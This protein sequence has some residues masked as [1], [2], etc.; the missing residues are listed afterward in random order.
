MG[1]GG[2]RSE[3]DGD[4]EYLERQLD[5]GIFLG[6]ANPR[7]MENPRNLWGWPLLILLAIADKE[8]ELAISCTQAKFVMIGKPT[9]L[10]TLRPTIFPDDRTCRNKDEAPKLRDRPN[11]KWPNLRTTSWENPLLTLVMIFSYEQRQ[12]PSIT[13]IWD[14]SRWKQIQRPIAKH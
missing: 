5:V 13:V 8:P 4:R 3:E 7:T 12:E 11:N 9:L 1:T 10:W 2:K 6:W 14:S